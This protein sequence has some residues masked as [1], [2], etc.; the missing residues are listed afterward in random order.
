[1]RQSGTKVKCVFLVV[2]TKR[3]SGFQTFKNGIW[4]NY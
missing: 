1:M 4:R 2:G 3:T